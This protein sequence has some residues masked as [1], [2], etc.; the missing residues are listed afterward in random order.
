MRK[1]RGG[2]QAEEAAAA[3]EKEAA[4]EREQE[5]TRV[6]AE[7]AEAARVQ[8]E[9]AARLAA[10]EAAALQHT[11]GVDAGQEGGAHRQPTKPKSAKGRWRR[12]SVLAVEEAKM[13]GKLG[14]FGG[15]GGAMLGKAASK[16]FQ[17]TS[18]LGAGVT[19]MAVSTATNLIQ[20][21]ANLIQESGLGDVW[22]QT[23]IATVP[24]PYTVFSLITFCTFCDVI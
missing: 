12:G 7:E 1:E 15:K 20:E 17:V 24:L 11:Q 22:E 19:A 5:S 8:A 13:S 21:S 4:A 9:A 16:G 14:G 3:M 18:N 23:G 6:T 2:R 10:E